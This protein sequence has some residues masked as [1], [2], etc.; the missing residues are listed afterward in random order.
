MR[1][2]LAAYQS[3]S[4]DNVGPTEA[5]VIYDSDVSEPY[6][7]SRA[8][9]GRFFDQHTFGYSMHVPLLTAKAAAMCS[10]YAST[11]IE[12]ER[13]TWVLHVYTPAQVEAVHTEAFDGFE[14]ALLEGRTQMLLQC[15]I[16]E[17]E[18]V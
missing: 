17:K 14:E 4:P 12:L 7:I 18:A 8:V 9:N 5:F 3:Q 16:A 6:G 10:G 11:A 1:Q 2:L 13:D 15:R